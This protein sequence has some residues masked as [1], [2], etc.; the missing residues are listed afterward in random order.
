MIDCSKMG[1]SWGIFQPFGGTV[2]QRNTVNTLHYI[3]IVLIFKF[4]LLRANPRNNVAPARFGY[5]LMYFTQNLLAHFSYKQ[6]A[7]FLP[8]FTQIPNI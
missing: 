1:R 2:P 8:K 3:D 6:L 5:R 4:E 7:N